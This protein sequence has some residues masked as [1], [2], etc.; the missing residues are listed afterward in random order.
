VPAVAKVTVLDA[1][2]GMFPVSHAPVSLVEVWAIPSLFV[3][4]M[5]VFRGTVI[6]VGV[7]AIPAITTVLGG[8]LVGLGAG[9]VVP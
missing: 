9:A 3:Q 8:V 1:P 7:N 6:V 2:A 5:V 4:V